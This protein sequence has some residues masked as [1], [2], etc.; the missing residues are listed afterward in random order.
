ML[1]VPRQFYFPSG[2]YFPSVLHTSGKY[3][4]LGKYNSWES[5]ETGYFMTV[6]GQYLYNAHWLG[7][8]FI[9]TRLL[10]MSYVRLQQWCSNFKFQWRETEYGKIA[11]CIHYFLLLIWIV[12]MLIS[13]WYNFSHWFWTM[14]SWWKPCCFIPKERHVHLCY[15]LN[16]CSVKLFL[17]HVC[18][19]YT[20]ISL[21]IFNDFFFMLQLSVMYLVFLC[22]MI[23]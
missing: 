13:F 12:N 21:S 20:I 15:S 8:A 14:Y 11:W 16:L 18:A 10:C 19:S 6:P 17:I 3:N 2:Q 23:C 22:R 5:T 1:V 7:H 9:R 4:P